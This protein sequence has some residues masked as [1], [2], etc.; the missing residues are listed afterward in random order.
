MGTNWLCKGNQNERSC[1]LDFDKQ[2]KFNIF[3]HGVMLLGSATT[4]IL[5]FFICLLNIKLHQIYVHNKIKF[6]LSFE[7]Q[8]DKQQDWK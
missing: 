2:A 3:N 7:E 8:P 6:C 4:N 1:D 5:T